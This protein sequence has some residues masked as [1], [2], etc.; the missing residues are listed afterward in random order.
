MKFNHL[1]NKKSKK[2]ISE[3]KI[4]NKRKFGQAKSCFIKLKEEKN[5]K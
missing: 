4:R 3:D 2:K 5:K 1:V